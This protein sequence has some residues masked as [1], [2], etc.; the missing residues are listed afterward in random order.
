MSAA[1]CLEWAE[2]LVRAADVQEGFLARLIAVVDASGEM[3]RW[4][5]PS[6][7]AWL[8][9]RLGMRDARAKERVLLARQLPRLP[10]TAERL[11]DGTL[12]CGYAVAIVQ[13]VA[14]LD[15][16]DCAKAETLLLAM[17]DDGFS[18]GKVAAFG[19]RIRDVI[20]ERDGTDHAPD[21]AA[22][23]YQR[24]WLTSTRSLDGGRYIKGWLNAEDAAVLDGTLGPLAKPAGPEDLRDLAERTAAALTTVLSGG[25]HTTKVTLI[26][27]LDTLTGGDS[28][29]RLPDG[30]PIPA[31]HARRIALSAGVSPLLLGSG[32]LPLYLGRRAR[33]AS[34]AQRRVLEALYPT[35]AVQGCQVPGTLAEVDH[36]DG[37][38]LDH[39]AT[40]IDRLTLCCGWH[41]RWRHTNPHQTHIHQDH[42]GRFIYQLLPP[43]DHLERRAE[44]PTWEQNTGRRSQTRSVPYPRIRPSH[45]SQNRPYD[46]EFRSGHKN[47]SEQ[48]PQGP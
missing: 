12:S 11:A 13:S 33:F 45:R 48:Q 10:E 31:E 39:G 43:P 47:P 28:P 5:Y 41:N 34:P 9:S 38:A 16:D 19:S 44:N 32:G 35:C 24:S 25:H 27:D 15:D 6:A 26:C 4:G 7:Q 23:G 42:N 21:D 17:A 37:W 2:T 29:A 8:R 3:R 20:A 40:D 46:H 18:A 36:V 22:R 14:R 30:T 1:V